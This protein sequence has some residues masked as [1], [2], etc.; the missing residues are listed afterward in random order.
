MVRPLT[1]DGV[2]V[3]VEEGEE[4]DDGGEHRVEAHVVDL[5]VERVPLQISRLHHGGRQH[6]GD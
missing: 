4:G 1:D 6:L 3:E 2:D 5:V